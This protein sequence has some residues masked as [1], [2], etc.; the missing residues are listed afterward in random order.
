MISPK[1]R[2]LP[3][4]T[5]QINIYDP[6]G[7]RTHNL[8]RRTAADPRLIPAILTYSLWKL[9]RNCKQIFYTCHGSYILHIFE[10]TD[11]NSLLL[12]LQLYNCITVINIPAA[13]GWCF[14]S[15]QFNGNCNDGYVTSCVIDHSLIYRSSLFRSHLGVSR[16][17]DFPHRRCHRC[18]VTDNQ[19]HCHRLYYTHTLLP[20]VDTYC[21]CN[22][23]DIFI[24]FL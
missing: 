23:I 9:K 15:F 17:I 18:S 11:D 3:D 14:M 21:Y 2:P 6:C 13:I 5:Q 1:Q 19:I 16:M 4:N 7:I 24:Y 12:H 22:I 10:V 20:T 8:S